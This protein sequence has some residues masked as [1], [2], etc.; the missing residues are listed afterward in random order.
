MS[1]SETW[2]HEIRVNGRVFI[3]LTMRYGGPSSFPETRYSV[4]GEAVNGEE[5]HGMLEHET[6]EA[7][8]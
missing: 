7:T 2:T 6:R 5:Y 4:D 8:R 3:R 1:Y